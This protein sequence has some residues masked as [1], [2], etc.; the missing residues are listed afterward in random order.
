MKATLLSASIPSAVAR[1]QVGELSFL[2]SGITYTS[3]EF[4]EVIPKDQ[5]HAI[6]SE[7]IFE[8]GKESYRNLYIKNKELKDIIFTV[9]AEDLNS[10]SLMIF[11]LT[12]K[13]MASLQNEPVKFGL[14]FTRPMRK[15][16]ALIPIV[17]IAIYGAFSTFIGTYS[18][19]IPGSS[20][21]LFAFLLDIVL[22][23]VFAGL[24][25]V[26]IFYLI[27]RRI[28]HLLSNRSRR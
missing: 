24:L 7:P 1:P 8:P 5:I 22:V 10:V 21:G 19:A 11:S 28:Y 23:P 25:L 9:A 15:D 14:L 13:S 27:P 16:S 20:I 4:T 12:N 18:G 17:L 3:G 6:R 2:D 26:S